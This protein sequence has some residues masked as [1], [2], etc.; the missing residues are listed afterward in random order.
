MPDTPTPVNEL[1]AARS[2]AIRALVDLTLS[3]E[4]RI[5]RASEQT[6][7]PAS[8]EELVA[9]AADVRRLMTITL[10]AL[11]R[12]GI[13]PQLPGDAAA[14]AASAIPRRDPDGVWRN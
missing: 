7:S 9:A 12:A 13:F 11:A 4:R 5:L 8:R 3:L 1:H 14:V 10:T 2:A 6:R